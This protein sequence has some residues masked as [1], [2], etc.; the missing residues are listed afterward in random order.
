LH[1]IADCLNGVG[2]DIPAEPT[3]RTA[4]ATQ[5]LCDAILQSAKSGQ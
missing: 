1:A 4:L 2:I 5:R 3:F